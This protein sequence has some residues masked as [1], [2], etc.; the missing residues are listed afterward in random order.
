MHKNYWLKYISEHI[1]C[2]YNSSFI[3]MKI[4][5]NKIPLSSYTPAPLSF[6][7]RIARSKP[8]IMAMALSIFP[9][10]FSLPAL[11]L[12]AGCVRMKMISIIQ[13][14][15][16]C[17]PTVTLGL[18]PKNPQ[19]TPS[20]APSLLIKRHHLRNIPEYSKTPERDSHP[21]PAT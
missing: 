14:R 4:Y 10:D 19:G 7:H 20:L 9:V 1:L 21:A 5:K 16:G 18:C 11:I 2:P 17:P 3:R 12:P 13:G 8:M 6:P 15:T